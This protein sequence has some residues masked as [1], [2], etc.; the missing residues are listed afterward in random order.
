M[1]LI[2]TDAIVTIAVNM[3]CKIYNLLIIFEPIVF[4]VGFKFILVFKPPIMEERN[5]E[6]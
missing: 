3:I 2:H 6:Q 4:K 1:D 5:N